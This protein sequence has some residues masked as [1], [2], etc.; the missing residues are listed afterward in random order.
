MMNRIK[1][2]LSFNLFIIFMS[3][4]YNLFFVKSVYAEKNVEK[5]SDVEKMKSYSVQL[6]ANNFDQITQDKIIFIKFYSPT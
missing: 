4:V 1:L 5:G 3:L 6:N 2:G